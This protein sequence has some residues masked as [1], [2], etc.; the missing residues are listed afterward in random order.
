MIWHRS[1]EAD[2]VPRTMTGSLRQRLNQTTRSNVV[3]A[4]DIGGTNARF[5]LFVPGEGCPQSLA[6]ATYPSRS[7]SSLEEGVDRFLREHPAKIS[8]ACFGVA[9][10]VV[11][12]VCNVT[13]L[14]WVVSEEL[15]RFRFR[16][17]KL[18]IVNDLFAMA[19]SINILT[20]DD[21]LVL[22][23]ASGDPNG[24]VAL[25]APGTG[26]GVSFL[27]NVEGS[28]YAVA[29]QG[30]HVD[31]APTSD[32][33]MHLLESLRRKFPRV[34][35]EHVASGSGILEIYR[36][37]RDFNQIGQSFG[38]GRGCSDSM[39]PNLITRRAVENSDPV[40]VKTVRTF[41][42][43]VGSAAGNLILTCMATKGLYLAGGIL[44]HVVPLIREGGLLESLLNKGQFR[45]L[46]LQVPV[47]AI[48][49]QEAGL[50]GAAR[51]AARSVRAR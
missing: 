2:Q 21:A 32:L 29:S 7:L 44:P 14:P 46:L 4:G 37:L 48:V 39:S 36:V 9:G 20:K 25:L 15:I 51:L 17:E 3:F 16:F 19:H 28:M 11:N 30:G 49:N 26:L 8:T 50:L 22:Q 27:F 5:G 45:D 12:G 18:V 1:F 34:T 41:L 33:E 35:L 40:C 23:D 13:N 31:F 24:N 43:I 6:T 47:Y 10:P 38:G 42:S